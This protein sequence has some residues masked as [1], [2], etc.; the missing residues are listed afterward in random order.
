M[1]IIQTIAGTRLDH[2]GTS[3]SVPALCDALVGLGYD[4]HLLTASPADSTIAC[5][6]PDDKERV[7]LVRESAHL[8]QWGV[9]K[10]FQS[11]LTRLT[12]S[13]SNPVVHDHA[14]WL[15]SNHAV[16][17]FCSQNRVHR[18]VSPRGMLGSWAMGHGHWKKKL[19]WHL[20]QRSDLYKATGFHATSEQEA[21][22]IRA[23]GFQQPIV[24]APN[25]LDVPEQLPPRRTC[26]FR[27]AL[28]LSRIHPKKGIELLLR[29][30]KSAGVSS[31]WRMLIAG[32]DENGHRLEMEK[33][34]KSLGLRDT[35]S[36]AGPLDDIAK[37]QAYVDSDLFV[38]PSH[39]ENFGIVIAE[40]MAAGLPVITTTG[41]PWR[42]L[43][44]D[45]M[46]WWVEPKLEELTTVLL[47]ASQ[48]SR[49]ELAEMGTRASKYVRQNFCWKSTAEKLAG[50]Y[51]EMIAKV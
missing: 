35:V 9:G 16:A 13:Q 25:G 2:G 26:D 40:A 41:T 39:N 19:A 11:Q 15:P 22:E 6:Y 20:Y 29:A 32:P 18:I 33:L 48:R 46:G 1:R 51:G 23:L 30:W 49:S 3:R 27:Q 12:Q 14:V 10:Q 37:W 24:V 28:F 43:V 4:N 5:N 34:V 44:N 31:Q 36:F 50:F 45:K 7:H 8:R 38:L 17:R 47:D 21:D 42:A